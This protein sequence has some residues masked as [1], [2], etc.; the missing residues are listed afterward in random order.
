MN[1]SS[2]SL[3]T[4]DVKATWATLTYLAMHEQGTIQLFAAAKCPQIWP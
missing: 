4:V 2:R 3:K 1:M